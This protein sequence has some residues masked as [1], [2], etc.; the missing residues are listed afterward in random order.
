M[1]LKDKISLVTGAA[2]GIGKA[3]ALR[4]AEEGS[5]IILVDVNK[6]KCDQT[7][8]EIQGKGRK[9]WPYQIDVSDYRQVESLFESETAKWGRL[10]VLVN[11]AGI[12]RD[13]LILRMKEEEWDSVIKINLK[14]VFNFCK[15]ASKVMM[16]QRTGVIINISSIIGIMGNAGQVNYSASKAGVIGITKSLAKELA[17]RNIR[18]NAVAPGFIQTAMTDKLTEEQKQLMLNAIPLK[19]IGTPEEVANLVLFLACDESS[20]TT[21]Q[22]INVDGGMVM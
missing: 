14:G 9:T 2:Q 21:G 15:A 5:D 1:K 6:E 3:I 19:R 13:N 12:T 10:D 16:K 17:S 22:V 4:L 7:A 18:V 20:Y 8:E 11:N